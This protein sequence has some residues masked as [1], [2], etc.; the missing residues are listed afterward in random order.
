MAAGPPRPPLRKSPRYSGSA[1]QLRPSL[2]GDST[3]SVGVSVR[4]DAR[5]TRLTAGP[6]R[7]SAPSSTPFV[8][9][10]P[11]PTYRAATRWSCTKR[12]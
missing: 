12:G 5:D 2:R 8:P 10:T 4:L 11:G 7:G 3:T 9:L 1:E 6:W